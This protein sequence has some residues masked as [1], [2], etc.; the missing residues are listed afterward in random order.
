MVVVVVGGGG[1]GG[2][3]DGREGGREG[4][5]ACRIKGLTF[6]GKNLPRSA[7]D[8]INTIAD[9]LCLIPVI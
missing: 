7:P 3:S 2:V 9:F 8:K 4:E 1:E 5:V 6:L